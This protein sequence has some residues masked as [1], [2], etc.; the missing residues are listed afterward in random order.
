MENRFVSDGGPIN[1]L[2]AASEVVGFAK[3]GGLADVAGSLPGALAR[4][5]HRCAVIMPLYHGAR[6]AAIAPVPTDRVF[7]VP[8]GDR[9]LPTRLWQS[10]LPGDVPVYLVEQD[11]YFDRD[12][13]V[14]GRSIYQYS[15]PDGTRRDYDDNCERFVFFNRAVLESLP[16]LD[17]WPDILHVND[18][19]TGFIP[20]CLREQYR[21]RSDFR[22][23][24]PYDRVRTLVTIHN[25]AFQGTFWH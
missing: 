4:R 12:D 23:R 5:G 10:S 19:Q 16:H 3:T 15:Q 7:S 18:W 14:Q 17:F 11:A 6:S 2:L 24:L 9:V 21:P 25:I 13:A 8:I 1:I 20:V 22:L